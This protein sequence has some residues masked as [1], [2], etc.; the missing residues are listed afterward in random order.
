MWLEVWRSIS[1]LRRYFALADIG[2]FDEFGTIIGS[3]GWSHGHNYFLLPACDGLWNSGR[4]RLTFLNAVIN[5]S[6]VLPLRYV[7]E[8]TLI[9]SAD[10]GWRSLNYEPSM[11]L[12]PYMRFMPHSKRPQEPGL[13]TIILLRS[14]QF[15]RAPD[16]YIRSIRSIKGI[17]SIK[18]INAPP[19]SFQQT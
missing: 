9:G 2:F 14:S 1:L 3:T 10:F 12:T 8:V 7:K 16:L 13:E 4:S 17:K 15:L 5:S 18:S 6:T 19:K 11:L